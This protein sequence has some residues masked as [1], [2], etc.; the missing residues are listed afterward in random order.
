MKVFTT[1]IAEFAGNLR[2]AS[3]TSVSSAVNIFG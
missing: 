1:E 3:V 2:F